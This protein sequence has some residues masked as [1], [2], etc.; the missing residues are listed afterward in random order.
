MREK[1]EAYDG[2][3]FDNRHDCVRYELR[4]A[5]VR[6]GFSRYE[7]DAFYA[8][9]FLVEQCGVSP[10]FAFFISSTINKASDRGFTSWLAEYFDDL[11]AF[12][13]RIKSANEYLDG[14]TVMERDKALDSVRHSGRSYEDPEIDW[15]SCLSR[16]LSDYAEAPD[17]PFLKAALSHLLEIDEFRTGLMEMIEVLPKGETDK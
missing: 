12:G 3:I 1:Y 17:D 6:K 14:L 15:E 2:K 9:R 8:A 13:A 4:L 10:A 7:G 11:S 16:F 5:W